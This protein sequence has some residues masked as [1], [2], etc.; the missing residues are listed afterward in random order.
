MADPRDRILSTGLQICKESTLRI[1]PWEERIAKATAELRSRRQLDNFDQGH[2]QR[3]GE[4]PL[5]FFRIRIEF[6]NRTISI[7]SMGEDGCELNT[8]LNTEFNSP[9][10]FEMQTAEGQRDLPA[11]QKS[12]GRWVRRNG[13]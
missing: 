1:A 8:E 3:I 9:A 11:R 5:L 6:K 4:I 13:L 12:L 10:V 2:A 7:D